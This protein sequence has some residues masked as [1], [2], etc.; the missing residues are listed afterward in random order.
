MQFS[1][2]GIAL[3]QIKAKLDE[4]NKK[5]DLLLSAPLKEARSHISD[6]IISIQNHL[7]E[8]AYRKLI[9]AEKLSIK[10][11]HQ[12]DDD[13][14]RIRSTKYMIFSKIMVQS[15][16]NDK[17]CFIVYDGLPDSRRNNIGQIIENDFKE[18]LSSL[19]GDNAT[20]W[21]KIMGKRKTVDKEYED[22]V[23]EILRVAYPYIAFHRGYTEKKLCVL[24]SNRIIED[25]DLLLV[26][27]LPPQYIP[28]GEEDAVE[29]K[30]GQMRD[31]GEAVMM[32]IYK[33][34]DKE[35]NW[36]KVWTEFGL[37]KDKVFKGQASDYIHRNK[38]A[39]EMRW[40]LLG[41]SSRSIYVRRYCFKEN[42]RWI[43]I[44]E[45]TLV[46]NRSVLYLDIIP[47]EKGVII[48][49]DEESKMEFKGL[50]SVS[51]GPSEKLKL[52]VSKEKEKTEHSLGE[53][54]ISSREISVVDL[55]KFDFFKDIDLWNTKFRFRF[56]AIP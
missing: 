41:F 32:R 36:W 42:I 52:W 17:K 26:P 47:N 56:E 10:G 16:S 48:Y 28:T 27:F 44:N 15:W 29:V 8:D 53:V 49:I 13:D 55:K 21:Q 45:N 18:L 35:Y 23:D 3:A 5:V 20:T 22:K 7:Y 6:A 34:F 31:S 30:I 11:F 12:S 38:N 2:D 37:S 24:D 40:Y 1:T 50:A 39:T 4:I 33:N 14:S 43:Q 9:D 19:K 46:E 25:D 54:Q 51:E